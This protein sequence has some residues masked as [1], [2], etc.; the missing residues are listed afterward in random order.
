M[1][2]AIPPPVVPEVGLIDVTIGAPI[3]PDPPAWWALGRRVANV[4]DSVQ[5]A[6]SSGLR[7]RKP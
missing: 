2:T 5:R 7:R 1:V 4:V 6:L 3:Q